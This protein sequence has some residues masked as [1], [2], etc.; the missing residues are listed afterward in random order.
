MARVLITGANRGLGRELTRL[1][2]RNGHEVIACCRDP[3]ARGADLAGDISWLPLDLADEAAIR[4]FPALLGGKAID[5]LIHNAA[6]RGATGGLAEVGFVDFAQVMR[7]NAAAPLILTHMLRPNLMAG[8]RRV[9]AMIS[10]RAG[11]MTE[12]LDP[13]GDYA[14]RCSKAA[15]NMGA[16]K[17]AYDDPELTVLLLHPGWIKTDMGGPEAELDVRE[18]ARG[19][20]ARIDAAGPKDSGSFRAWDGTPI[21]W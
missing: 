6:I 8:E 15:L 16:R 12:G 14:Y 9:V 19:L 3:D 2:T 10:S 21:A 11:S 17:L 20:A 18:A 1:Y 5:I 7:V 13:D 4:A